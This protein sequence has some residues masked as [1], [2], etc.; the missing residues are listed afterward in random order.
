MSPSRASAMLLALWVALCAGCG[1]P[2][3][4]PSPPA[5]S[6]APRLVIDTR[7]PADFAAGHLEGVTA[8]FAERPPFAERKG[9][10][11]GRGVAVVIVAVDAAHRVVADE[12][13]RGAASKGIDQN[14]YLALF[15]VFVQALQSAARRKSDM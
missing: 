3:V 1:P 15:V 13:Q 6:T 14:R 5:D 11:V 12:G 8:P 2:R 10:D 7:D 9:Q 4:A